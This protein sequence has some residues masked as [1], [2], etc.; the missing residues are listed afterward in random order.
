MFKKSFDYK[1]ISSNYKLIYLFISIYLCYATTVVSI[2]SKY[3]HYIGAV[4]RI[5]ELPSWVKFY[6]GHSHRGTTSFVFY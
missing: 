6:R 2:I 3:R 4:T 5:S 1:Y